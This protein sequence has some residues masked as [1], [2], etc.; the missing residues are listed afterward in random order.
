MASHHYLVSDDDITSSDDGAALMDSFQ[1][2]DELQYYQKKKPAS[3]DMNTQ[4]QTIPVTDDLA[5]SPKAP[6]SPT[7]SNL[8]FRSPLV[9]G[10][11]PSPSHSRQSSKAPSPL[12]GAPALSAP[13]LT[14]AGYK[15]RRSQ[16]SQ[17]E[18]D[19]D[20]IFKE[21][22]LARP[23][24]RTAASSVKTETTTSTSSLGKKSVNSK[25]LDLDK[26]YVN[27]RSRAIKE[28][29]ELDEEAIRI[30]DAIPSQKADITTSDT[31][32]Q[33]CDTP[34]YISIWGVNPCSTQSIK[35]SLDQCWE[36]SQMGPSN[37]RSSHKVTRL[38]KTVVDPWVHK[39]IRAFD[40]GTERDIVRCLKQC[41]PYIPETN[42]KRVLTLLSKQSLSP[43]IL[44]A[45]QMALSSAEISMRAL[46]RVWS[47]PTLSYDE[48]L[49]RVH[50]L[51]SLMLSPHACD[52]STLGPWLVAQFL[53]IP[54]D[55]GVAAE[56]Q[57]RLIHTE[58][59]ETTTQKQMALMIMAFCLDLE[60]PQLTLQL[61][62]A[63][64]ERSRGMGDGVLF[65]AVS[66]RQYVF[67]H[68]FQVALR[69]RDDGDS[70]LV[71]K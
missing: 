24:K 27:R 20:A 7:L 40:D 35:S 22:L 42:T 52:L 1:A 46:K 12:R 30:P 13:V 15:R 65:S 66:R 56:V 51:S 2:F 31:P 62:N 4:S 29:P 61:L 64:N 41:P 18:D 69:D 28:E 5:F 53:D 44:A 26:L 9:V 21:N 16:I 59:S 3:D 58:L 32:H 48:L 43:R 70:Q 55:D 10:T 37:T 17:D 50:L 67:K 6:L 33:K 23:T 57:H 68:H 11:S 49:L 45:S 39:I 34:P 47:S 38:S 19:V 71:D 25:Q 60:D 54:D 36:P 14:S 8:L 63:W